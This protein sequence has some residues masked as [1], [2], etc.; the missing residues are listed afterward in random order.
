MA[1]PYD[2]ICA[3]PPEILALC[4]DAD[5]LDEHLLPPETVIATVCGYASVADVQQAAAW[6][7]AQQHLQREALRLLALI[8]D[9]DP[10]TADGLSGADITLPGWINQPWSMLLHVPWSRRLGDACTQAA[11]WLHQHGVDIPDE[12]LR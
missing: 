9:T 2:V 10:L 6:I 12:A 3:L 11:A 5:D 4:T 8:D 1:E 7:D